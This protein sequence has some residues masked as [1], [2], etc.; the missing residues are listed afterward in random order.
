MSLY[1]V[2]L[3]EK[4]KK[5]NVPK[6]MDGF[7]IINENNNIIGLIDGK[8]AK[9]IYNKNLKYPLLYINDVYSIYIGNYLYIFPALFSSKVGAIYD[10]DNIIGTFKLNVN[11]YEKKENIKRL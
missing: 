10:G 11:L 4:L 8:I 5:Y 9:G 2:Q 3:T 6:K 1:K 7:I